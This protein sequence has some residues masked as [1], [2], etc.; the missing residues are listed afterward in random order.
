MNP[1]CSS[2]RMSLLR[3]VTVTQWALS[4]I[5]GF[6][7][8]ASAPWCLTLAR[9]LLQRWRCPTGRPNF[10]RLLGRTHTMPLSSASPCLS[11]VMFDGRRGAASIVHTRGQNYIVPEQY[12]RRY[13]RPERHAPCINVPSSHGVRRGS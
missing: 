10:R 3:F 8:S 4:I 7:V 9:M 5:M 1:R 2:E 6:A 13:S 12:G 11:R